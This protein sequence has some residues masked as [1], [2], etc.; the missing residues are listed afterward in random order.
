MHRTGE[1]QRT[2]HPM[3]IVVVSQKEGRV[4]TGTEHM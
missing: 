1:A 4:V 3:G 2:D